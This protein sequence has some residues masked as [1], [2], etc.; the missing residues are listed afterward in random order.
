MVVLQNGKYKNEIMRL[1]N[2]QKKIKNQF[3]EIS[4]INNRNQPIF[5]SISSISSNEKISPY[6]TPIRFS[7][8]KIIASNCW[9][10]N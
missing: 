9:I 4:S 3:S 2:W 10:P 1:Q 8:N 6:T 5:Y 7:G